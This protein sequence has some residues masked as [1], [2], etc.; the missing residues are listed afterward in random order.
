MHIPKRLLIISLI[1]F[2]IL[3]IG[4]AVFALQSWRQI[5]VTSRKPI[6]VAQLTPTPDPDRP[7]S[8]LLL[9]YGGGVHEGGKNTD[10]MMLVM[11]NPHTRTNRLISIPRDLWVPLNVKGDTETWYKINAA[12]PIGSNDRMYPDKKIEYTGPAGGGQMTKDIVSKITGVNVDYFIALD[13]AGFE[14][15][16]NSLGKIEVMVDKTFDDPFYPLDT[17]TTDTCGK[18]GEDIAAI[19]ATMSGDKLEQ[20]FTCRYENLHFPK[21]LNLMDGPTALKY[22]RSR[23]STT[24]GGDFNRARRQRIVLEAIKKKVLSLGFLPKVIPIIQTLSSHLQTDLDIATIQNLVGRFSDFSAYPITQLA[25]TDTNVLVNAVSRNG[26]Y[27]LNPKSGEG[28]W[29]D[30]KNYV[31]NPEL[32][33]PTP[34]ASASGKIRLK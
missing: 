9:G 15:V 3:L 4:L 12:Y 10:S 27:I 2:S 26:Q 33:A 31:A 29:T 7:F 25:L 34:T 8:I 28:D 14:K 18:S 5:S 22:A 23:H 17:G 13:F 32:F 16:V 20:Q 19:S 6:T 21:G 1:G 24:D 30:I 11:V